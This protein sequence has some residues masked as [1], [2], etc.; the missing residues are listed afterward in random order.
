LGALIAHER[1]QRMRAARGVPTAGDTAHLVA[2]T[3]S[4]AAE[5]ITAAIQALLS[6]TI[7]DEDL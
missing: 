2:S 3:P 7:R 4:A 6:T 1:I 5:R